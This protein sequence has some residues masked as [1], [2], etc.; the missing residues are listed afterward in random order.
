MNDGTRDEAISGFAA[1]SG[2]ERTLQA[3]IHGAPELRHEEKIHYLGEFRERVLRL[4]TRSQVGEP[5]VYQEI[6][7]AIRDPR[8]AYIVVH[9]EISDKALKK[10][11]MLAAANGKSVTSRNDPDFEGEAGLVV[12]SRQ[13]VDVEQ[14]EV[15]GREDRLMKLGLPEQLIDAAGQAI[16]KDCYGKLRE[17]APEETRN[18]RLI[19]PISRLFGERCPAH[20]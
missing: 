14:V 10:Y 2:L 17:L 4:L 13:A 8:A 20:E 6:E 9:S 3:G 5:I 1:K 18:Y 12:V 16:C 19:S 7:T 15:E 11:K